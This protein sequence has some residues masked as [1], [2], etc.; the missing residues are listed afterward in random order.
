M[1][2]ITIVGP[3]KGCASL[4]SMDNR[5]SD[6]VEGFG[7]RWAGQARADVSRTAA[8]LDAKQGFGPGE[9]ARVCVQP[10]CGRFGQHEYI[11][12]TKSFVIPVD[13]SFLCIQCS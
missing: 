7:F 10:L 3:M 5:S 2:L 4:S 12:L 13:L 9:S 8:Y 11:S 1:I 6:D